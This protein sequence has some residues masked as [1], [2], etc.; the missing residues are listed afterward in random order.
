MH[1]LQYGVAVNNYLHLQ[2][3][4]TVV[5]ISSNHF[6]LFTAL[7]RSKYL[8]FLMIAIT[9]TEKYRSDR[10]TCQ[11][12]APGKYQ[13][14]PQP[15]LSPASL[16]T[17]NSCVIGKATCKNLNMDVNNPHYVCERMNE[18]DCST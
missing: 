2:L 7:P 10:E 12:A 17:K 6:A 11:F 1:Y 16:T 3:S 8:S 4:A 14:P 15:I 5:L 9:S 13:D 18:C